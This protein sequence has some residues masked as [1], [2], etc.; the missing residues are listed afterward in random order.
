MKKLWYL[1]F[2]FL[3]SAGI[4]PLDAQ[5]NG[6]DPDLICLYLKKGMILQG[7]LLEYK[8]GEYVKILSGR[9][10]TLIIADEKIKRYTFPNQDSEIIQLSGRRIYE[11]RE[12]GFYQYTS[13]GLMMNTVTSN[14]GGEVGLQLA[15]SF[16]FQH[17]RLLGFG[18]GLG[19][20]FYRAGSSEKIF[21]VFGEVRGYF[22]RQPSTPYYVLRGG[23]GFAWKNEDAGVIGARGGWMFNPSV[24]WRLGGGPAL[25]MT[26]DVGLQFQHAT[27]DYAIGRDRANT[28][29]DYMRLNVRMGFLF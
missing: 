10:H 4:N 3:V 29:I 15:A 23:Y 8:P 12:Q 25:K 17:S 13:L 19:A 1:L 26:L 20:D 28:V 11:F 2:L 16:G 27:F 24:G 21:P 18:L 9:G 22:L 7:H 14:E 5:Q 6:D